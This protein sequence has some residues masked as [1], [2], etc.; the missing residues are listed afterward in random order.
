MLFVLASAACNRY[1]PPICISSLPVLHK[2]DMITCLYNSLIEFLSKHRK[3]LIC[4]ACHGAFHVHVNPYDHEYHSMC[5]SS[6]FSYTCIRD[7]QMHRLP[8]SRLHGLQFS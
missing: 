5:L 2:V 1:A 8:V 7:I 4:I 6:L 3:A